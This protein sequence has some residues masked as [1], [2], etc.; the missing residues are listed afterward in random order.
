MNSLPLQIFNDVSQAQDRLVEARVGRR[1]DARRAH[2]DPE[3]GGPPRATK[4]PPRMNPD[5]VTADP[6]RSPRP[7]P[8]PAA[9]TAQRRRGARAAAAEA[10]AR[11]RRGTPITLREPQRLLRRHARGQGTSTSTTPP[12]RVTAMIGPSGCGK[13]TLV[14]C[15]NR[16]HEEIPG[17]RA[18]GE[19]LLDDLDLYGDERRRGRGA[20]RDRDGLPEA[21][22]VPDDVDLR[23]RRRRAAAGRGTRGATSSERVEQSLRGAGAVGRG[24]GPARPAGHR[25]LRRPAAAPVHRAH[26]RGRARGDPHGRAVLGARPDRDAARSRS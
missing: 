8:T 26:D 11:R 1:A 14:R 13:S 22:P 4:E 5:D 3:P 19:V 17:A 20:P 9:T 25:P 15:I 23:Q 21:Q 10:A 12:N 7:C 2:P 6:G 24:Q 18:D 16:M